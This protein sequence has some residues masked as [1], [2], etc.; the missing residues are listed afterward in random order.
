VGSVEPA[1]DETK[2]GA[3]NHDG[4]RQGP[5]LPSVLKKNIK[6][7]V[8]K[9]TASTRGAFSDVGVSMLIE[10]REKTRVFLFLPSQ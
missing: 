6:T 10:A 5:P 3:L 2:P 7:N 4:G 9:R 8:R 1:P